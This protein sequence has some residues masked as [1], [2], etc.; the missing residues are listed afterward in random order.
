MLLDNG[1]S[2]PGHHALTEALGAV[3][4]R[5]LGETLNLTLH[6]S[7]ADL[8]VPALAHSQHLHYS[9]LIVSEDS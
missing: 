3:L 6:F 7:T 5:L 4:G 2:P 9:D 1:L 8:G